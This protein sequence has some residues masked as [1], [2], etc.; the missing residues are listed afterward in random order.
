MYVIFWGSVDYT[1]VHDLML[2]TKWVVKFMPDVPE[3]TVG[4]N[5]VMGASRNLVSQ[6]DVTETNI[7]H[8]VTL[9]PRNFEVK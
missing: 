9:D 5:P 2:P 6:F 8:N 4:G 7:S 1:A 3:Q